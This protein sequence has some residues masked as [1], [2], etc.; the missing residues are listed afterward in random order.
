M[1]ICVC[2][3]VCVCVCVCVYPIFKALILTLKTQR[4][5]LLGLWPG[6]VHSLAGEVMEA[7]IIIYDVISIIEVYIN[8]HRS[9]E[10]ET[11]LA[12]GM[13]GMRSGAYHREDG[14]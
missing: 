6:T 10:G 14:L 3:Y 4:S 12:G 13:Q 9:T 1:Y 5:M 11:Y 8:C 2:V 7:N